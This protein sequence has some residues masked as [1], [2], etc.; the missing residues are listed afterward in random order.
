MKSRSE[1]G[2]G[3]WLTGATGGCAVCRGGAACCGAGGGVVGKFGLGRLAQAVSETAVTAI[4][5]RRRELAEE[6]GVILSSVSFGA[7]HG[8]QGSESIVSRYFKT[9]VEQGRPSGVR[10]SAGIRNRL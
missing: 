10:A 3:A 7:S 6:R 2:N 1:P 9:S 4:R 5:A 8:A